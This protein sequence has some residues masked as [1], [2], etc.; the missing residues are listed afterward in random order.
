MIKVAT[1]IN[2]LRCFP[3]LVK[4][5]WD[6]WDQCSQLLAP[7]SNLVGKCGQTTATCKNGTKKEQQNFCDKH[8]VYFD[9]IKKLI[10]CDIMLAYLDFNAPFDIY[11][12]DRNSQLGVIITQNNW[13]I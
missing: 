6:M 12:D 8:Q 3:G 2:E 11:M 5:L 4:Y 1:N 7:L 9:S 10:A 13:K